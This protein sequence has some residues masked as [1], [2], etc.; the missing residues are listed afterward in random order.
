MAAERA[1]PQEIAEIE[2]AY[3]GMKHAVECG[4][5][6]VRYDLQFHQ[7]LLRAGRN[8]MLVQMSKAIGALLRTSFEVSTTC[9]TDRDHRCRC[10][11]RCSTR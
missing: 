8:R 1:Q 2:A 10:I 11:A 6:Y 5:D 9:R 7:G 3:A 4:G